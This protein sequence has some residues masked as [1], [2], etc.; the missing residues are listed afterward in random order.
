[1]ANKELYN[2][3]GVSETATELEIRE[4]YLKKI[5]ECDPVKEDNGPESQEICQRLVEAY[6]ILSNLDKR[7]LY[8]VRGVKRAV[9]RTG[10][11]KSD[12]DRIKKARKI[13]NNLFLL[14]AVVTSIFFVVSLISDNSAP[15]YWAC[16]ASLTL[17][18]T[19]Y[20]LR[21]F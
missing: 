20:I 1:M 16:G 5:E 21:L 17:K 13:L 8:D 7:A 11:E 6:E 4:A 14:G 12:Y 18:I 9:R 3:L 10:R 15:F 19:E 2:L